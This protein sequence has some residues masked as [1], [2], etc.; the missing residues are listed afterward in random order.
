MTADRSGMSTLPAET[1]L[2]DLATCPQLADAV[3]EL[4]NA[5]LPAFMGWESPGNW[6][7]HQIYARFPEIQAC[8]L[9]PDGSLLGAVNGVPVRWDG[10]PG[11]LPGGY[12]DVLVDVIDGDLGTDA[13]ALCLLSISVAAFARGQRVPELLLG[14][15]REVAAPVYPAGII[16]PL[17]PTRKHWYP[18]IPI[19]EYASWRRPDGAVFDPW[20]R[21]HVASGAQILSFADQSLV[22]SQPAG[23]WEHATGRPMPMPGDYIVPGALAPVRCDDTGTATY[24]EPNVW[25]WHAPSIRME[26]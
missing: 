6:R 14:H 17:R 24:A 12:D 21:T 9:S 3:D 13:T 19:R 8:L 18:L 5:N 1:T 16:I 15:M 4:L 20:L 2:T 25:V 22:I 11:S 23:R 26:K 10:R 7:W